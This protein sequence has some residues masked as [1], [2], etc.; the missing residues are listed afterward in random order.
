MKTRTHIDKDGI[1]TYCGLQIEYMISA[2]LQ[3]NSGVKT[4]MPLCSKCI[5]LKNKVN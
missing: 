5:K 1:T 2:E 4:G 3:G